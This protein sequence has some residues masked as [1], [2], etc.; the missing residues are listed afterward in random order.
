M[1][2]VVSAGAMTCAVF[3][4]A[5]S[6]G[7]GGA[8]A[9]GGATSLPPLPQFALTEEVTLEDTAAVLGHAN[10]G[11]FAPSR[12]SDRTGTVEMTGMVGLP[13]DDASTHV[14]L[15]N[16]SALF[17]FDQRRFTGTAQGFRDWDVQA[18]FTPAGTVIPESLTG[19]PGQRFAGQLTL[20]GTVATNGALDGDLDGT[21]TGVMPDATGQN[22][23]MTVR[24][25]MRMA[26]AVGLHDGRRVALTDAGGTISV[27]AAGQTRTE[28]R[29]DGIVFLSE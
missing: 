16:A 14:L 27:T 13:L 19:T 25:D 7:G 4:A 11:G 21:L 20:A 1:R 3:L 24:I 5:C 17:E 15:G 23:P 9:G 2:P 8:P 10:Q 12:A 26:G 28:R 22:V 29:D 18:A 6:S